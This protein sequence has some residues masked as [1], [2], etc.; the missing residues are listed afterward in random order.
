MELNVVNDVAVMCV[1]SPRLDLVIFR[2]LEVPAQKIW[3]RC[4]IALQAPLVAGN[5]E[6]RT[7]DTW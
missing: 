3:I 1:L 2:G 7:R 5:R 6:K 4:C